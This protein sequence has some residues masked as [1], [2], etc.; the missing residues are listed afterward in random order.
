MRTKHV[1]YHPQTGEVYREKDFPNDSNLIFSHPGKRFRKMF[2]N[3]ETDYK[4][5]VFNHYFTVLSKFLEQNTNRLVYRKR[6]GDQTVHQPLQHADI[7]RELKTSD[8]TVFRF[9]HESRVGGYLIESRIVGIQS[10]FYM[11]PLYVLNGNGISVELYLL[12]E[13]DKAFQKALTKNDRIKINEYIGLAGG[14]NER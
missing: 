5:V 3:F 10:G 4:T 2:S 9:L 1:D 6:V 14:T 8:R 12:F 7:G 11:N 13:F